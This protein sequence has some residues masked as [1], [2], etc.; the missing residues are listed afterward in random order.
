MKALRSVYVL[1]LCL[2]GMAGETA[3]PPP[4]GLV[5]LLTD[6]GADSIYVGALKGA[7]YTAFPEARIDAITNSVPAFDV[8][9]GAYILAEAA[10]EFPPGTTFCCVVDPGVGTARKGIVLE[11]KTGHRFAAPD[12][13]LLH[14]AAER[15]GVRQV[16][17]IGNK[18]L[19]RKGAGSTTFHGRDIFGPVSAAL[20]RGVPVADVGPVLE[21]MTPLDAPRSRVEQGIAHGTV[22]RRDPYGNLVTNITRA[23]LE[24]LGAQRGDALEVTIG[25]AAFTAPLVFTY[26]DVPKGQKLVLVQSSGLVECAINLGN[27]AES[28]GEGLHAAVSI[29]K[30]G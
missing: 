7:I 22:I 4:N 24:A 30:A 10:K 21:H 18:A 23:D 1:L 27:L 28:I 6:Y 3:G 2:P 19:W 14:L 5:I 26:A 9:A 12:N 11:T 17:E 15:C 25:K 13:G 20:A 8:L 16:R 29:R